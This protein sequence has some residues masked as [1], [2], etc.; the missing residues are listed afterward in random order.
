MTRIYEQ[1]SRHLKLRDLPH[2]QK[3]R[4]ESHLELG[5]ARLLVTE[6][7]ESQ[8]RAA[9]AE[10]YDGLVKTG[11]SG[12]KY[13]DNL[14]TE[15]LIHQITGQYG[16]LEFNTF[17]ASLLCQEGSSQTPADVEKWPLSF[18]TVINNSC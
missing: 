16:C 9:V 18:V 13:S 8:H 11:K 6:R 5:P 14:N 17:I 2:L 15:H 12:S 7:D 1:V 10:F 3:V 4:L